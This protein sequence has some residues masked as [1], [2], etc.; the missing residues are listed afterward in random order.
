[1]IT[2]ATAVTNPL[3]RARLRTTSRKPSLK[4][5]SKKLI[6]PTWNQ[7][8]QS[9]SG[10]TE[11]ERQSHLE[12]DDGG[13]SQA[14]CVRINRMVV[15]VI[16]KQRKCMPN[17]TLLRLGVEGWHAAKD[18]AACLHFLVNFSRSESHAQG[19]APIES[20]AALFCPQDM[21]LRAVVFSSHPVTRF[22]VVW[23]RKAVGR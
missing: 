19:S 1:M 12:C 10:R 5:P 16:I 22:M 17:P 13:N 23:R 18:Q 7:T 3:R 8:V 9:R 21:V 6:R 15:R 2:I 20:V 14:D 11:Y 4:M